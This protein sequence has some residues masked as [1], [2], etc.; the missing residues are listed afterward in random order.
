MLNIDVDGLV[1]ATA[2]SQPTA[3]GKKTPYRTG[4]TAPDHVTKYV[5]YKEKP[6]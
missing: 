5:T 2:Y 4:H 3:A 6:L 1:T